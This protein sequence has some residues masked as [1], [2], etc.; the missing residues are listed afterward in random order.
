MNILTKYGLS[1]FFINQVDN[2]NI[3]YLGRI[4]QEHKKSFVV[5]THNGIVNAIVK[6]TLLN[7]ESIYQSQLPK[8]GD[9]VLLEE[10]NN[11]IINGDN[12]VFI[13]SIL[14]RKTLLK[15]KLIGKNQD[16]I[17]ATNLDY[18]FVCIGCDMQFNIP[19]T[20]RIITACID[21]NIEPIILLTKADL[22]GDI[23]NQLEEI[24]GAFE[25]IPVHP[26]S[27][28]NINSIEII[29]TI[30]QQNKT[31]VLIGSSGCGKSSITN[32]L[33]NEAIQKTQVVSKDQD[34]GKHTTTSRTI[35]LLPQGG[36]IVDTPGI[37]EFALW[38]DNED[39]IDDVFADIKK[40]A[41]SCKFSNCRH[42]VNQRDCAIQ[43]AIQRNEISQKRVD[44]Y[45]KLKTESQNINL[46]SKT[47]QRKISQRELSKKVKISKLNKQNKNYK[48][49]MYD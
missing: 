32:I 27:I 14:N 17:I 7:Y 41:L 15:R 6:G 40:L 3:K 19:K 37:K 35:F 18:A 9:F 38:L 12:Y 8:V 11:T 45:L 36:C 31:G 25:N 39:T 22:S 34:K 48:N 5:I 20:Q 44:E 43:D 16:Q 29:N 2:N 21:C 23:V 24:Q 47:Y 42:G 28:L 4:I 13:K 10:H 1:D 26:I 49:N 46:H 33:L 30:L